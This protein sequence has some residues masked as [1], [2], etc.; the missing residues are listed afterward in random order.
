[1]SRQRHVTGAL[2]V[3]CGRQARSGRWIDQPRARYECLLCRTQVGPVVGA[4]RVQAFVAS[5][6]TA[7]RATC[8]PTTQGAA[9]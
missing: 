8:R 9:A 6:R 5:I 2:F 1:M 4:D 7:H 3:D